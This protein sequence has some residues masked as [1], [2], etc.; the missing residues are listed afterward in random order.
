MPG[1]RPQEK[2]LPDIREGTE[3][4]VEQCKMRSG[5]TRPPGYVRHSAAMALIS[6]K[7]SFACTFHLNSDP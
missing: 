7:A 4:V 6:G 1:A 2:F 5:F 3:M